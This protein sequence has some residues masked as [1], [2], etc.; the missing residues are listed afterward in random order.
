M[1]VKLKMSENEHRNLFSFI[2]FEKPVMW[3]WNTL[4]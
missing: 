3:K 1:G 4:T 2:L